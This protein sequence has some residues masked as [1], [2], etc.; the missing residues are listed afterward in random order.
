MGRKPNFKMRHHPNGAFFDKI[1]RLI[2]ILLDPNLGGT[3]ALE[4]PPGWRSS[5][6]IFGERG[7]PIR[8]AGIAVAL[9]PEFR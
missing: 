1:Y 6:S 4:C 7:E 2:Y 9:V 3:M 8:T 5:R